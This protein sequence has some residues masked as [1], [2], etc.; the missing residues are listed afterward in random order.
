[1][2][3]DPENTAAAILLPKTKTTW[4]NDTTDIDT[5]ELPSCSALNDVAA[6]TKPRRETR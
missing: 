3:T 4:T 1:M 2:L 5:G 6:V